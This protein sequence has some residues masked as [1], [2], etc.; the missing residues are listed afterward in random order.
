[1]IFAMFCDIFPFICDI[2]LFYN[3]LFNLFFLRLGL[4][5]KAVRLLAATTELQPEASRAF[6]SVQVE[7]NIK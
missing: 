2:V 6:W 3:F 1:M 7:K 5:V 4:P